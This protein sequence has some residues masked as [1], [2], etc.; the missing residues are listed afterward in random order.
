MNTC[1]RGVVIQIPSFVFLGK[2]IQL[3]KDYTW[4]SENQLEGCDCPLEMK[5]FLSLCLWRLYF[6]V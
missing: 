4:S 6:F 5:T 2:K 3:Q 1:D